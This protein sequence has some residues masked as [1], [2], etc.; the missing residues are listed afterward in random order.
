MIVNLRV[1]VQQILTGTRLG[2]I[3]AALL[4][5]DQ[6]DFSCEG[7]NSDIIKFYKFSDAPTT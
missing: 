3:H 5:T 1:R 4:K 2:D 6:V 7:N